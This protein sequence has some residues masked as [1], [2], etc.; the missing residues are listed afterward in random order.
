MRSGTLPD[1]N[2]TMHLDV[3]HLFVIDRR[4]GSNERFGVPE[5]VMNAVMI[6]RRSAETLPLLSA[7]E[8][9]DQPA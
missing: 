2:G 6:V 3:G 1:V 4:R 8:I 9:T 5:R 7:A